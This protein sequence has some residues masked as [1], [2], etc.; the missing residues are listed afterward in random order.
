[1]EA[2]PLALV[3]PLIASGQSYA[4]DLGV[5]RPALLPRARSGVYP[6]NIQADVSPE[7]LRRF[8]SK[9]EGGYRISRGIRDMCIFAQHI[10]I[11][12]PGITDGRKNSAQIRI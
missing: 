3:D 10:E 12:N 8:F 4:T 6:D 11:G 2:V 1:M 5:G 7:R 9:I